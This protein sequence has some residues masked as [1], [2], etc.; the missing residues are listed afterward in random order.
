MGWGEYVRAAAA[1]LPAQ[2][3]FGAAGAALRRHAPW[4]GELKC[5][6]SAGCKADLVEVL[7]WC[8]GAHDV[9]DAQGDA[10]AHQVAAACDTLRKAIDRLS[11]R[12]PLETRHD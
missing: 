12:V 5:H 7:R 4:P 11:E 1:L 6:C 10:Q 3:P 2:P 9:L 8:E